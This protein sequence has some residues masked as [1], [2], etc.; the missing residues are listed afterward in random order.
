MFEHLLSVLNRR[1]HV[2]DAER[3]L[4]E[5]LP[6]RIR[7]FNKGEELVKE[8]SRPNESCLVLSGFTARAQSLP[9]GKRQL[10]ALHVPGDSKLNTVA[11]ANSLLPIWPQAPTARSL[12]GVAFLCLE[13]PWLATPSHV[14][15]ETRAI[16]SE[17]AAAKLRLCIV[18]EIVNRNAIS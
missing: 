1:D 11:S 10:T 7:S 6:R 4:I 16:G 14:F 12:S 2:S 17:L 18:E 8:G 5:Q 3:A 15:L 13:Y 9:D